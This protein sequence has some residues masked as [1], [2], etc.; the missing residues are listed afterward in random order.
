MLPV[1]CEFLQADDFNVDVAEV[2]NAEEESSSEF[3]RER[4]QRQ[5]LNYGAC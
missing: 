5:F 3:L 4:I 2:E 1:E